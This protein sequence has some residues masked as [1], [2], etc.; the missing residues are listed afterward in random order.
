M[1]T[2]PLE[3]YDDLNIGSNQYTLSSS[4][5][6]LFVEWACWQDGRLPLDCFHLPVSA[7]QGVVS[8]RGLHR[9][10]SARLMHSDTRRY[11]FDPFHHY[12]T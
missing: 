4:F 10:K 12:A 6:F 7:L 5:L 9:N 11:E 1:S 8:R 3:S 2:S